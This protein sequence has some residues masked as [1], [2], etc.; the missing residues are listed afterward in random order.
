LP[1]RKILRGAGIWSRLSAEKN[2]FFA[3]QKKQDKITVLSHNFDIYCHFLAAQECLYISVS[4]LSLCISHFSLQ[5]N[6]IKK[7]FYL[8]FPEILPT[9]V[10]QPM[11][12]P[13][14]L[15]YQRFQQ[16]KAAYFMR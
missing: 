5:K 11:T 15:V 6:E 7:L 4:G 1:E 9:G 16:K 12:A 2:K 3:R 10:K 8:V 13:E 14:T